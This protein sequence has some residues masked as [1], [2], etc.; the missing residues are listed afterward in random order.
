MTTCDRQGGFTLLELVIVL[1]VLGLLL[2]TAVPLA[3]AVVEADRRQEARRELAEVAVALESFYLENAAF[4][5]S[6]TTATFHGIHLQPGVGG[7]TTLD[8]FGSG[9]SYLYSVDSAANTATIY[10]RGENGIDNGV[11]NEDLVVVVH[12]AVPG[13]ARTHQR[14]RLIVEV[15]ANHIEG[16]G[17]VAGPWSSLRAALGLGAS[18]ER[19]GFGTPLHWDASTYTLSSAGPDRTLG[20]ADDIIL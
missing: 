11:A 20:S 1:A 3:G 16:G 15:L 4:P 12:G 5:A 18:Y 17:S 2:G 7:T 10:S 8:P 14:L 9:Q 19:D 13:T 6:L